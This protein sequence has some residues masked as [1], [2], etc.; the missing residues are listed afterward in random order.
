MLNLLEPR[1]LESIRDR[2]L[3]HG[4]SGQELLA[5]LIMDQTES[6]TLIVTGGRASGGM[7]GGSQVGGSLE[8]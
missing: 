6:V 2:H 5:H 3:G 1:E 7:I 4:M 8:G